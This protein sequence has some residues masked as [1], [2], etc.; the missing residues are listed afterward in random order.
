[1]DTQAPTLLETLTN[2]GITIGLNILLALAIFIIGRWVAGLLKKT[3]QK[4]MQRREVEETLT[5]FVGNLVYI[6]LLIFVILAVLNRLGIQTTS[7]V[8]ILA[9]AGFAIGLALQGGL[10]NFAAGVL[11]I[12][13]RPFKV[14]DYIEGAGTAGI[15]EA[16]QI[17]TTQLRTPDNKTIIIPNAAITANNIT[18]YST[19][20]TRRVDLVVGC[21]YSDD[22]V[23]VK[24]V[25]QEIVAQDARVLTEP[26]PQVAVSELGDSSVNFV[27]RPWVN[28]ADYWDV[29]FDMTETVK[30]RFDEEGISIPFPQRDVHIYQH[31][32][33]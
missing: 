6:L 9:S 26:A 31:N 15:V 27:L 14:G 20:P 5:K 12:I 18:N 22:L 17:F 13:F 32:T 25:L 1:M 2:Q 16:I 19:K 21:G 10:A 33:A 3:T 30:R 23:K 24:K 7:F 11:L 29:Y 28:A 4:I 8:A